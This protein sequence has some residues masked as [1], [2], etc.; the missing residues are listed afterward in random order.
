MKIRRELEMRRGDDAIT[1]QVFEN[2]GNAGIHER[3]YLANGTM[4]RNTVECA[5]PGQADRDLETYRGI[6]REMGYQ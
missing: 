2:D 1:Y 4:E 6:A 5:D 3:V